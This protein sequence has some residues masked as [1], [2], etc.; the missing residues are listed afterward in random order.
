MNIGLVQGTLEYYCCPPGY[1]QCSRIDGSSSICNNVYYYDDDDRQCVCDRK[2]NCVT[3]LIQK[4]FVLCLRLWYSI[5]CVCRI[6]YAILL[7]LTGV[8]HF[9]K[10]VVAVL[11]LFVFSKRTTTVLGCMDYNRAM[12]YK[13]PLP[14]TR[15]TDYRILTISTQYSN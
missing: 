12:F 3:E 2:G 5:K 11:Q 9:N 6:N 7:S 1:C 4:W 14:K 10:C 13:N 8:K 15:L